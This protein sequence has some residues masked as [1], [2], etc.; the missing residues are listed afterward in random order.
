MGQK[1]FH[2]FISIVIIS[3]FSLTSVSGQDCYPPDYSEVH[4]ITGTTATLYWEDYNGNTSW[5]IVVS[6]SMLADP[7]SV[8]VSATATGSSEIMTHTLQGLSPETNYYYY[9]QA[10]CGTNNNSDWID[11]TFTTRCADKTV[12]HTEDFNT[13]G[14]SQT[15]FPSCWTKIQGTA[16][17]TNVDATHVNVLKIRGNAAVAAPCFNQAINTLRINFDTWSANIN[18]PLEVGIMEDLNDWETYT[19]I[20][21][22]NLS[23]ASTFFQ[24]EVHFDTYTGNGRYIVFNNPGIYDHYI[25]NLVVS[26][27]PN[28]LNP[29]DVSVSNV[30][31]TS[32]SFSWTE[33]GNA[34]QWR[35]L[36]ST[37]PVTNFN[38]QNPITCNTTS[39][40]TSS[41][42]ANTTYYFYV[43]S[44][45]S[46]ENSEWSSATFTTLCGTTALPTSE[47]FAVNQVPGCWSRERLAGTADIVFVAYS[48][49]PTCYPAE[50]NAM[51]KW[52]SATNSVNWQ[53]RLVSLPLNTSGTSALDVNFKW[54]HD[55]GNSNGLGDGVQIQYSTDG[56]NWSNS[57]QGL[58]RRYDGVQNGWTE[59]DVI[60]PEA[61]NR[62]LVYVGF[63]FNTGG[64]G[65]NC[66]LDDV[67]FRA[68]SGCYMPVNLT[69]SNISGNGATLTWDEVG[70]ANNWELV[71]SETPITNFS[72]LTPITVNSTTYTFN[73]LNPN[74]SY[75]AYVRSKCSGSSY[76][77]WSPAV[78]FTTGCGTILNFPYAESFDNYG[79]CSNAFPPCWI[80]H[81]Q[82]DL[83]TFYHNGQYCS[84]PSATDLN[85]IDGDKSLMICTPSGSF[86]YTISPALQEDIRN[87]A[88]TFFLLKSAEQMCGS[89]EVGVMSDPNDLASFESIATIDPATAGEW[90]FYPISFSGAN[91]S[92]SG[93][94]VAFR[95]NGVLDN[96]YYLIDGLTIMQTPDCWPATLLTA[97]DIT[98]NNVTLSWLD[99]NEPTAQWRVKVSDAPMSEMTQ[100]ANVFDQTISG[101]TLTLDYL[102]G[103]TTYHYYI[104]SDCG[105]NTLGFWSHGSFTTL[106][107]NCYV[108]IYM[109]DAYA[110]GWEGA[111]I[112]LKHGNTVFAE[113]TME[114]G[115]HDTV[116]IYTC[117]ASNI[118][119]Y[120][121][122]GSYDSDISFTIVNSLGTTIYT[123]NGTPNAGCFTSGTPA[124]GISC[125][126]APSNLTATANANGNSL[127]WTGTPNAL[128]YSVYRNNTLIADYLTTTSYTDLSPI[129]GDN[130]YTVT[131]KC[132]AG[133]SSHSTESCI[134]G[135]N[136]HP[137]EQDVRIFPNPAHDQFTVTAA[138]P[139]SRVSVVN[140]LGQEVLNKE[141]CG[142]HTEINTSG[143]SKGI[144]LVKISDGQNWLVRKI[145]IE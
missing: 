79:T 71:F 139:F 32:A 130:C 60:L 90:T 98:G 137:N 124:C 120:F 4:A 72:S 54:N 57:T 48:S 97:D 44:V 104:Q 123:T 3:L 17:T 103:S 109:N 144:Y 68:A 102:S 86:T 80:R 143:F 113:A 15:S 43:Q 118:D 2:T 45:C 58:I 108:D 105:D 35:V 55:I 70:S 53:S 64:G 134:T 10:H 88:V 101:T 12:P 129:P 73:N 110:N 111:K 141:V 83:G 117:E 51:V 7:S 99:P 56:V 20:E 128:T 21:N 135:I 133:E 14:S 121:V 65:A 47:S 16:Y 19:L 1:L 24:K 81:G 5:N 29:I 8:Q 126:T 30:T 59:Y 9:I 114:T 27:I 116:R 42:S 6:T 107:C 91:L 63:L 52:S 127:S 39:Y 49:S 69:V 40:N 38:N 112:Q 85:A 36:L 84:T 37:T 18:V 41:L 119:Y 25:D 94:R 46:G 26:L 95:H 77:A 138:F 142:N 34:T 78:L 96:N 132:V 50:G 66:Y 122:S 115:A 82:P 11:G 76:S 89:F 92:G 67:N 74:T 22:I 93:N 125:N 106:P 136:E 33:T 62:P 131:A 145:V 28:C 75:Y 31:A 23:S 61:G 100:T 13:Y 87:L 140:L